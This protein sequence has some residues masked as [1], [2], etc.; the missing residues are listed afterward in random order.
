MVKEKVYCKD[1]K[2]NEKYYCDHPE[3]QEKKDDWYS[4]EIT[5]KRC[6]EL[7]KNNDC[8]QFKKY[9]FWK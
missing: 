2:W 4:R 9:S 1:C 5:S 6:D 8:K 7:N 3:N